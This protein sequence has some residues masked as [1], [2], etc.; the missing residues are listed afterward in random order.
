MQSHA[1][2][3]VVSEHL[4]DRYPCYSSGSFSCKGS[5][6]VQGVKVAYGR[7]GIQQILAQL[8]N[9]CNGAVEGMAALNLVLATQE[10]KA[11][12][13]RFEAPRLLISYLNP[14]VEVAVVRAACCNLAQLIRLIDGCGATVLHGGIEALISV[15][16]MAP[17]EVALCMMELSRTPGGSHAILQSGAASTKQLANFCKVVPPLQAPADPY[18]GVV[19][20]RKLHIFVPT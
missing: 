12:A 14:C 10:M 2:R 9:P 1:S 8:R 20:N 11:E 16:D 17:K 19:P 6:D 4:K 5:R 3:H 13:I 7:H 18:Y 15:L